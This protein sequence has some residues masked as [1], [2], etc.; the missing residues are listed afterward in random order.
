MK[1]GFESLLFVTKW[2]VPVVNG[3]MDAKFVLS[4]WVHATP[5]NVRLVVAVRV[6]IA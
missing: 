3:V 6:H 4:G 5:Q 1:T 2:T